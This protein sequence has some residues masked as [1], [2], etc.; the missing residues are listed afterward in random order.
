MIVGG[1]S[2]TQSGGCAYGPIILIVPNVARR[3]EG[4]RRETQGCPQGMVPPVPKYVGIFV[5]R[6]HFSPKEELAFTVRVRDVCIA[7]GARHQH[8]WLF[9]D[10]SRL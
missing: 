4:I 3:I 10:A 2:G 8:L 1:E 9:H 5:G 6:A 7:G